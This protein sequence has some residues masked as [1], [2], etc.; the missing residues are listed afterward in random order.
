MLNRKPAA[1]D[2]VK[3]RRSLYFGVQ[4]I[5]YWSKV[6]NNGYSLH[7]TFMSYTYIILFVPNW[8]IK[9]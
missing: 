5:I 7:I 9:P 3:S 4:F 2:I 8:Y 1:L 6:E